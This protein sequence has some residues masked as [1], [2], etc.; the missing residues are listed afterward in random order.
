MR[1]P[2]ICQSGYNIRTFMEMGKY[3]ILKS[4]LIFG[5]FKL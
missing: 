3:V 1:L 5:S 2:K 4:R